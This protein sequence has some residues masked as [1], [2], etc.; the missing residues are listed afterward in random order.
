MSLEIN[1]IVNNSLN[2]SL[3]NELNKIPYLIKHQFMC[4]LFRS[5]G[6]EIGKY[7][8][9]SW[10]ANN[11]C[12]SK[13]IWSDKEINEFNSHDLITKITTENGDS[14]YEIS[15]GF[16]SDLWRL[17]VK[18]L[19]KIENNNKKH[20]SVNKKEI[21]KRSKYSNVD[22]NE[23]I[24]MRDSL[25]SQRKSAMSYFA[26]A[27]ISGRGHYTSVKVKEGYAERLAVII[28]NIEL[29]IESRELVN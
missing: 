25:E 8:I 15:K 6:I 2:N 10:N 19:T 5:K 13:N 4:S 27:C 12:E 21:K 11:R 22:T 20:P 28:E 24:R 29:E 9:L 17:L 3:N 7:N 1:E 16:G 18:E 23:L 26:R 14:F